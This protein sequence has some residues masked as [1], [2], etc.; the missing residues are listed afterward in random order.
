MT[1]RTFAG[2]MI[3]LLF[4]DL[5]ATGA[6][7]DISEADPMAGYHHPELVDFLHS[8]PDLF[9]IDARTGIDGLWQPDSAALHGL[10]DVWGVANPLV[11]R[12]WE[13]LWEATGGRDSQRYDML[14]A[15]YVLVRD[16]T[17]L[18][19]GKFELAF[20][21]PGELA[22]YRNQ[23]W[24]PRAWLV[25][26]A[27]TAADADQ[28]LALIAQD[29]EFDPER[30][31]IVQAT[32][33]TPGLSPATGAETV[34]VTDYAA[35]GMT[36]R[37]AATAPA[38]LVLSEAWYPGWRA[39]VDGEPVEVLQANGAL[40]AV[41]VPAGE[42]DVQLRFTAPRWQAGLALAALGLAAAVVLSSV[43]RRRQAGP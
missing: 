29:G 23:D 33:L 6:Y 13:A 18:P 42:S 30:E 7:T 20:D 9:R 14:N 19:A 39:T 28:A 37:V 1:A 10:Q 16:G 8:D 4:F 22:V 35:D 34:E 27:A 41:A 12:H 43:G 15:K 25:H 38:Y 5:A 3:G 2:L 26:S 36:L 40:R 31:V 11:L 32:A 17:P 24:L 21:A